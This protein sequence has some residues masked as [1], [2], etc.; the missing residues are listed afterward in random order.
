MKRL[1]TVSGVDFDNKQA[2]KLYRNN[3]NESTKH[4]GVAKV[5]L[6]TDHRL[7]G[8]KKVGKTHSHNARSGG[9]GS[10]FPRKARRFA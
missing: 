4:A 7:F 6:G 9:H 2:A 8:V 1:F 5:S 10:G 3:C